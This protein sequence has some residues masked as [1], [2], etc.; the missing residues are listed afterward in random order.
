[1]NGRPEPVLAAGGITAVASAIL[2]AFW[3][4]ASDL[5]WLVQ[6]TQS[7]QAL[8]TAAIIA[9]IAFAASIWAR[10]Q[11]TPTED[12]ML[13]IGTKVKTPSGTSAMVRKSEATDKPG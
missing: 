6:I 5:G 1:M 3:A 2:A 12:P 8:V 10:G 13:E 7:T 9:V 11:V 4:V